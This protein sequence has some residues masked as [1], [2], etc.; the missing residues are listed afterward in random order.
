MTS[1]MC[2]LIYLQ[3]R[4]R[5]V[6]LTP[7]KDSGDNLERQNGNLERRVTS[8]KTDD[9]G[10]DRRWRGLTTLVTVKSRYRSNKNR[11]PQDPP[12]GGSRGRIQ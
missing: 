4:V 3:A 8:G 5:C 9:V 1:T 7:W 12:R 10:K 2:V 6:A 11:Q